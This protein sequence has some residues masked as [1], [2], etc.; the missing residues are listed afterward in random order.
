M[1]PGIKKQT[2]STRLLIFSATFSGIPNLLRADFGLSIPATKHPQAPQRSSRRI[3]SKIQGRAPKN[4]SP[5]GNFRKRNPINPK[6]APSKEGTTKPKTNT[7]AKTIA[8]EK[9]TET[10]HQNVSF[11]Y[12]GVFGLDEGITCFMKPSYHLRQAGLATSWSTIS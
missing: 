9:G 8:N 1:D 5:P 10:T 11:S 2:V 7:K 6:T 3:D 4:A 12:Q